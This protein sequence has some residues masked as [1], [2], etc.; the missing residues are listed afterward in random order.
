MKTAFLPEV[1][2]AAG[3]RSHTTYMGMW[4]MLLV[5]WTRLFWELRLEWEIDPQYAHGWFIPVLGGMLFFGR[6]QDRPKA[7]SS[8]HRGIIFAVSLLL[9]LPLLPLKFLG[10]VYPEARPFHWL[11]VLIAITITLIAILN[12]GGRPWLRHFLYPVLFLLLAVPWARE[13]QNHVTGALMR[14]VACVSVEL[15]LL[16][17]IPATQEGNSIELMNQVVGV[18]EACSG[19]RSLQGSIMVGLFLGEFYRLPRRPRVFLLV[20]AVGISLLLNVVR[21]VTLT[22]VCASRGESAFERFHDPAGLAILGVVF[23]ISVALAAFLSRRFGVILGG[24]TEP[25]GLANPLSPRMSRLCVAG[26]VWLL[27]VEVSSAVYFHNSAPK[28]TN[29][30]RLDVSRISGAITEEKISPTARQFLRFNAGKATAI[31]LP[32][33]NFL[34]IIDLQWEGG[35]ISASGARTHSPLICLPSI[36]YELERNLPTVSMR[37]GPWECAFKSAIFQTKGR[38]AYVYH[39]LWE[40]GEAV[41][42]ENVDDQ[43]LR[44]AI[45]AVA[46]RRRLADAHVL[47]VL[48]VGP[49]DE[50]EAANKLQEFLTHA[51]VSPTHP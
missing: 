40:A 38:T 39:G 1:S 34:R 48:L 50:G 4:I 47:L 17:G 8:A 41:T 26:V 31:D 12:V 30:W 29:G 43:S 23:V 19:I 36:G 20:V 51:M 42:M 16:A 45:H 44:S 24:P 33:G 11:H 9:L 32:D 3:D 49:R 6:W 22:W 27:L 5:L 13:F 21:A 37:I 28:S 10:V 46:T 18:D 35:E 7:E 2:K 15:M 25:Y 14:W